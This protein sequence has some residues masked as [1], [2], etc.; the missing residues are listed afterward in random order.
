MRDIRTPPPALRRRRSA[1]RAS[2]SDRTPRGR[3]DDGDAE[4]V[5]D[6]RQLAAR[7]NRRGGRASRR[8]RRC[9]IAGWPSKYFSSMRRPVWPA[10][11]FFAYSRGY[12]LRAEAHR[13]RGRAASTPATGRC[14][15]FACWPLRMRVSISPRGSVI[16]IFVPLPARLGDAGD[17]ALVGQFPQHDPRQA[18]TCDNKRANGRSARSG[19]GRASGSRCAAARPSSAARSGARSRPC[20]SSFA[21]AFSFAYFAAYF[22]T[23]FLRRSFLLI[24][25]SFAMT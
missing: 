5:A 16:A 2:A 18:G 1:S 8:G 21:I 24:E 12:S 11:R 4:A 7:P 13:A 23:S 15:C 6:A 14:P 17:Q 19:C 25:L 9:W 10:E 22:L 3:R 20:D